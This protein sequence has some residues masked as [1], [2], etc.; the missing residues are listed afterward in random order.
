M[1][2]LVNQILKEYGQQLVTNLIHAC[3]FY[4][5]TYMLSEVADVIV[6]M[7]HMDRDQMGKYLAE[8]LETLPKQ[9]NGG[10]ISVTPQQLA[11][12]HASIMR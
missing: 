11:D 9:G 10:V 3:V 8:T 4:L 2:L 5:H 1:Q 12:F 7:L 6:E